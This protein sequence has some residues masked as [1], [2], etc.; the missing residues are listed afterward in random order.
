MTT[1][2]EKSFDFTKP[3]DIIIKEANKRSYKKLAF[4][5][6][7]FGVALSFGFIVGKDVVSHVETKISQYFQEKQLVDDNMI[8]EIKAI[9]PA[10]FSQIVN[11]LKNNMSIYNESVFIVVDRL[12]KWENDPESMSTSSSSNAGKSLN[13][14]LTAHKKSIEITIN[15]ISSSY[16]KIQMGATKLSQDDLET[17]SIAFYQYKNHVYARNEKLEKNLNNWLYDVKDSNKKDFLKYGIY[18]KVKELNSAIDNNTKDVT[19][20]NSQNSA[21]PKI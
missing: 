16:Q 12:T 21:K 8:K 10:E 14:L 17:F 20:T 18:D 11:H 5:S 7:G 6:L 19:S 15:S 3:L 1:T 4:L 9:T 13:E 2:H